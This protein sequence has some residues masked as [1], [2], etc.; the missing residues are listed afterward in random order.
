MCNGKQTARAPHEWRI[1]RVAARHRGRGLPDLPGPFWALT[2]SAARRVSGRLER[3]A[4]KEIVGQV[5]HDFLVLGIVHRVAAREVIELDVQ[6]RFPVGRLQQGVFH[7]LVAGDV[8]GS[9]D[10]QHC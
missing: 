1:E 9:L 7:P 10:G 6:L 4:A 2:S 5:L 8:Q 3:R